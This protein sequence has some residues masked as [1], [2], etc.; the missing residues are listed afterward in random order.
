MNGCSKVGKI[1]N[2]KEKCSGVNRWRVNTKG[3]KT[4]QPINFART[5]TAAKETHLLPQ[6]NG[7]NQKTN[8][9]GSI[10]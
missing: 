9:H 8:K 2:T 4:T 1:E 7:T 5:H 6:R 3:N 10:N